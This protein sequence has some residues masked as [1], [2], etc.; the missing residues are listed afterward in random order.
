MSDHK[1]SIFVSSTYEDLK[2][3]RLALMPVLL[4]KDFI[5]VGME[6]FHAAPASQ[7]DVI[8][9][10]IDECDYYLLVVK[11]KYGSVDKKGISYTERE[12]NYAKEHNI[13]I[14][15]FLPENIE[16]L[17]VLETDNDINKQQKLKQFMETIKSGG[18]TVDFYKNIDDLRYKVSAS[19]DRLIQFA[20]RLGWIRADSF[21]RVASEKVEEVVKNQSIKIDN[22]IHTLSMYGDILRNFKDN[23]LVW[24]AI[25]DDQIE[26]LF[27][28][29]DEDEKI[30][31]VND[32]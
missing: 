29:G 25:S 21:N 2:E 26:S 24:N 8:T 32:K 6:L 14:I 9:K 10:M 3:E 5:P 16:L 20:P 7:W 4:E 17:T 19:L 15:A 11:G 23:T 31:K 22:M 28:F 12:Y 13:P 1:Y 18:N 30:K 27:D